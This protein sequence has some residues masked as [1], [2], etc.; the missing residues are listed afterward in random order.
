MRINRLLS[1]AIFFLILFSTAVLCAAQGEIALKIDRDEIPLSGSIRLDLTFY[2]VK[3]MPPPQL[4]AIEG[5][6]PTHLRSSDAVS[7]I[8]GGIVH[9]T[10]H[11]YVLMPERSGAFNIGPFDIL[12]DGQRYLS[13][14]VGV[15]VLGGAAERLPKEPG[16]TAQ[17]RINAREQAFLLIETEKDE[18]YVNEILHVGMGLY[19]RDMMLT[20]IR[21]PSLEHE[22]FSIGEFIAPVKSKKTIK[23]NTYNLVTFRSS[24]F[25]T[26]PGDLKLGPA[27]LNSNRMDISKA[28]SSKGSAASGAG[29]AKYG[30]SNILRDIHQKYKKRPFRIESEAKDITALPLP[31]D[32]RPAGFNGAVGDFR[33]TLKLDPSGYVKTG[34]P[35]TL[36]MEISGKGNMDIVSPPAIGEGKDYILYEP[37]LKEQ[38]DSYKIFEQVLIPKTTAFKQVPAIAFSFF[39]PAKDAY[40]T[41]SKGPLSVKVIEAHEAKEAEIQEKVEAAKTLPKKEAIGR[42]IIYI[43]DAPGKFRKTGT[44]LYTQQA[45]YILARTACPYL[46]IHTG[47]L[48]EAPASKE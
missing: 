20:D 25:A 4:P 34:Q 11:T 26:R 12:Y 19:Y 31:A 10:R 44:Y 16:L 41:I 7:R 35:L 36:V 43:K 27:V 28:P 18:V 5:F 17:E 24:V 29:A 23:G 37:I 38:T 45:L 3:D 13:K 15:T 33:F 46:S 22:G 48:Q 6:K 8:D 9:S 42:D 32:A 21:R 39:D 14:E 2:G 30:T 1:L 47:L 40:R